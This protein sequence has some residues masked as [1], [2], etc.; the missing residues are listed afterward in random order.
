MP[1]RRSSSDARRTRTTG[2]KFHLHIENTSALGPV[3]EATAERVA[4]SAASASPTAGQAQ[5][6]HRVRR[7]HPRVA[8]SGRRT[9]LFAWEFD[10]Q[11]LAERA[12]R[13]R[14]IHAHGAGV[15]H[16]MPLDWLPRGAVLTNS[17]GVHGPKA[18]EY[19]AMAILMLNN[20]LPLSVDEP[21]EGEVGAA[22]QYL[23]RDQDPA[24]PR[25]GPCRRRG[26]ALGEALRPAS[27]R[28]PQDGQ[29][30][31]SCRRDASAASA[32]QVCS[33]RADFVAGDRAAD[34]GNSSHDRRTGARPDETGSRPDQLQPGQC[35]RTTRRSRGSFG[36]A[37]S[38]PSSTSSIRSRCRSHRRSGMVPNLI[39]TPPLLVRRQGAIHAPHARPR[40]R[41]IW[42]GSSRASRWSTG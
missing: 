15:S 21:A 3:F 4:G 18:D 39:I 25:R 6:H 40:L 29:A 38:A 32:A 5:D 37:R 30:A 2:S 7:R 35:R 42:S 27:S 14:W 20:N 12:P 36:L 24:D 23:D 11:N 33:L 34:L 28:H 41:E 22:V 10:R 19:T 16:L 13:L 31:R 17:R 1:S 8:R 9:P 26:R